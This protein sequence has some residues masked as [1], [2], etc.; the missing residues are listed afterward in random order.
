LQLLGE[1]AREVEDVKILSA[2]TRIRR[3]VSLTAQYTSARRQG[4]AIHK[5]FPYRTVV[6]NNFR[7]LVCLLKCRGEYEIRRMITAAT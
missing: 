2:Y 3:V 5:F 1:V 7:L 4:V 6:A